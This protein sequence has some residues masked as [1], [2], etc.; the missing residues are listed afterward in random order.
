MAAF[1]AASA[2]LVSVWLQDIT[3]TE[4]T[5]EGMKALD[6][7]AMRQCIGEVAPSCGLF[8]M[9]KPALAGCSWLVALRTEPGLPSLCKNQNRVG[10]HHGPLRKAS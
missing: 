4:P 6:I 9:F 5:Q 2:A 8:L 1:P 7:K 3:G 10:H